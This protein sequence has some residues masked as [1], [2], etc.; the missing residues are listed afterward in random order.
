MYAK[1]NLDWL[2][3]SVM[4]LLQNL[5]FFFFFNIKCYSLIK[6]N[7]I[8]CQGIVGIKP[9]KERNDAHIGLLMSCC[10]FPVSPAV[11]FLT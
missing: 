5:F 2:L 9:L 3:K 10:S 6:I 8:T 11:S 7:V 4:H 1:E